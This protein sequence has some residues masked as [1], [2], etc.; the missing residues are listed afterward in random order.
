MDVKALFPEGTEFFPE[1]PDSETTRRIQTTPS[2]MLEQDAP[3]EVK[4]LYEAMEY[5]LDENL[6]IYENKRFAVVG[7]AVNVEKDIHGLASVQLSDHAGGMVYAHCI[8][9]TDDVLEQVK[10]GQKVVI[11]SN[12]LVF[13]HPYGVVMKFSE[14][15]SVEDNA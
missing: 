1:H 4:P 13:G 12:Y 10:L 6:P 11:L 5:H 7:I 14:L 15:V 8:F 3:F 2:P 9:P